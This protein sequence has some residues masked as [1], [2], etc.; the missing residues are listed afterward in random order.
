MSREVEL[1]GLPGWGTL[2]ALIVV[3]ALA[4]YELVVS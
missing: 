4:T 2:L 1:R 3:L